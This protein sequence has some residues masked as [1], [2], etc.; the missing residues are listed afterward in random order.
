MDN[1]LRSVVGGVIGA[2]VGIALKLT[3]FKEQEAWY[4]WIVPP[5]LLGR[6]GMTLAKKTNK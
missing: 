2:M 5:V 3:I 1:E 4:W 6:L